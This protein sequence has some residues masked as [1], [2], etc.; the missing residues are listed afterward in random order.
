MVRTD[1][2]LLII[3]T[4][5]VGAGKSTTSAA[6]A[7][8]LRRPDVAVAVIDLDQLYGMV[9]QQDGYGEPTAWARA[10]HGAGV[11]ANALFNTGMAVVVV[12]GELFTADEL[13]AVTMPIQ[14][15]IE[16]CFFTLRLSYA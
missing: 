9:R 14:A 12:E 4:G 6:L 5:P 15:N 16:C 8:S 3:I 13:G 10:R 7:R 11:L 2:R 1:L